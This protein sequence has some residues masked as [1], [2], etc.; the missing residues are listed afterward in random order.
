LWFLGY[1]EQ[2]LKRNQEALTLARQ[3]AHPH[4][5]ATAL[6]QVAQLHQF[7]RDAQVTRETAQSHMAKIAAMLAAN[8]R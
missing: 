2:A 3:I 8:N 7:R 6:H 5:V 4:G 1:P